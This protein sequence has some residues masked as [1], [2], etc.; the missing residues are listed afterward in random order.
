M[1]VADHGC[2]LLPGAARDRVMLADFIVV[3]DLQIAAFAREILVERIGA[4][5]CSGGNLIAVAH[6]GPALHKYIGLEH[7]SG[8]DRYVA[9]DDAEFSHSRTGADHGVRMHSRG[10]RNDRGRVGRH[11]ISSYRRPGKEP[12]N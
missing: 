10:R 7:A 1:S 8:S 5:R 2:G 3:S 4:E 6:G 12:E 11:E 9:L